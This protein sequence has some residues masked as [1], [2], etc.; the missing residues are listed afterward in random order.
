MSWPSSNFH[1]DSFEWVGPPKRRWDPPTSLYYKGGD[2]NINFNGPSN[3][4]I[5]SAAKWNF[6]GNLLG[7]IANIGA[8]WMLS[9][10]N[11]T[12]AALFNAGGSIFGGGFNGAYGTG[13][14]L[15]GG[16]GYL[17][18]DNY[19]YY[20]PVPF[21]GGAG[22]NGAA[23]DQSTPNTGTN[24]NTQ[25]TNTNQST[26]NTNTNQSTPNTN[27][28]QSTPNTNTNQSTPNTNTNQS[29]PS[30]QT[31]QSTPGSQ[32]GN[33]SGE[34]TKLTA[35]QFNNAVDDIWD[36]N[37]DGK[38]SD[39]EKNVIFSGQARKKTNGYMPT[40]TKK[41]KDAVRFGTAADNTKN[42]K[43]A[44]GYYKYVTMTDKDSGNLWTFEF[45]K[46]NEQGQPIYKFNKTE[47]DLSKDDNGTPGSGWETSGKEP[48]Y[49][50]TVDPTSGEIKFI[51]SGKEFAATKKR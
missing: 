26:P 13:M 50:V 7:G 35:D 1:H 2:I 46:V 4:A 6:F 27:T 48:E 22:I 40:T 42:E 51:S 43:T 39:D 19:T 45:V 47:S 28:N 9:K 31:N 12:G 21:G 3:G 11:N 8:A 20:H 44:E 30:S 33:G 25:N 17:V 14:T 32:P 37:G 15:N 38:I 18:G 41:E 10:G 23:G 29:T 24:Q 16:G 36:K 34:A 5:K 49:T